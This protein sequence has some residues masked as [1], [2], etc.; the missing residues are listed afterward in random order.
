MPWCCPCWGKGH[1]DKEKDIDK[2]QEIVGNG[3]TKDFK[4]VDQ[5]SVEKDTINGCGETLQDLQLDI[6][7]PKSLSLTSPEGIFDFCLDYVMVIKYR[8]GFVVNAEHTFSI[9]CCFT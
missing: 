3:D 5:V 1:I 6:S 7:F 4:D 9:F 2:D 8:E